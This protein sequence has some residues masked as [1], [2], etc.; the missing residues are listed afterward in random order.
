MM[1]SRRVGGALNLQLRSSVRLASARSSAVAASARLNGLPT[2]A[3]RKSS[4][5]AFKI[6]KVVNEPN[7]HYAKGSAQQ[8][9]LTAA[10]Q[11]YQSQL[12]LDV[13]VV[14]DGQEVCAFR[15]TALGAG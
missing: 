7:Q 15:L 3:T 8:Q 14:I 4:L 6:P 10:L 9:G 1:S 12:P 2:T 13:P 11:K 5:A